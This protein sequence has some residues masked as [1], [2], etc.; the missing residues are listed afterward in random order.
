MKKVTIDIEEYFELKDFERMFE[1]VGSTTEC[2]K[3]RIINTQFCCAHCSSS[4]PEEE[5]LGLSY[6][7]LSN[8]Y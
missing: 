3:G 4:D 1:Q 6:T 5:C 2:A 7:E 8:K